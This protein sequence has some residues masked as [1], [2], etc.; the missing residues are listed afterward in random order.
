M[1]NTIYDTILKFLRANTTTNNDFVDI[2]GIFE[3][4]GLERTEFEEILKEMQVE[5]SI[6]YEAETSESD[7]I[8]FEIE[9]DAFGNVK[10]VRYGSKYLFKFIAKLTFKELSN[11]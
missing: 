8:P 5:N 11:E 6:K 2:T 9:N 1:K 4:S 7:L 10:K 3:N